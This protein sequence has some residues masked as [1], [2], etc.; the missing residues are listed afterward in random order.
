MLTKPQRPSETVDLS[1]NSPKISG[2]QKQSQ[3]VES[4]AEKAQETADGIYDYYDFFK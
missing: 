3:G 2:L 4:K 1:E